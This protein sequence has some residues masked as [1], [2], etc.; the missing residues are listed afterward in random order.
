[1]KDQLDQ[2]AAWPKNEE[3]A[4]AEAMI[5]YSLVRAHAADVCMSWSQG[6][7]ERQTV[8]LLCNFT[9]A[10]LLRDLAD[11]CLAEADAAAA[12]LW[13]NYEDGGIISELNW[14]WLTDAGIDPDA[15]KRAT[16]DA[17]AARL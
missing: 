10:S 6:D 8:R 17:M 2:F 3:E 9:A 12:R 11:S 4:T 1:M 16:L 7:L 14:Q 13:R 15:I 5:R